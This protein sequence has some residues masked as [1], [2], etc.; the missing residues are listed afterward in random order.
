MAIC[1]MNWQPFQLPNQELSFRVS[2]RHH[3][4]PNTKVMATNSAAS[5][6]AYSPSQAPIFEVIE[7]LN[8]NRLPPGPPAW[9]LFGH[10]FNL[11][12]V[13]HR[14]I[15]KL[16]QKYGYIVWLKIGPFNKMVILTA[17]IAND[18][19]KNLDISFIDHN[20]IDTMRSKNNNN[21]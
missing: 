9:P 7:K 4:H 12:T 19:F 10:I 14:T 18:F 2:F 1:G 20:M 3:Q 5:L 15:A 21:F 6:F 16:K 13:P 8:Y 17:Y 11:G